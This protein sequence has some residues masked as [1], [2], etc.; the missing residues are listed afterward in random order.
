MHS[1]SREENMARWSV[2]CTL[3]ASIAASP[4]GERAVS[5]SSLVVAGTGVGGPF[6]ERLL[7]DTRRLGGETGAVK[8]DKTGPLLP[9]SFSG[10]KLRFIVWTL[11]AWRSGCLPRHKKAWVRMHLFVC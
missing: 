1:L 8:L 11:E 10:L 6:S 7:A 9:P 4:G 3:P 2:T 5:S